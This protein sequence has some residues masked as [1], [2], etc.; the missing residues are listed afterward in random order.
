MFDVAAA[1][2]NSDGLLDLIAAQAAGFSAVIFQTSPGQFPSTP[3]LILGELS[4]RVTTADLNSDGQIDIVSA[5]GDHLS[6]Y[7]AK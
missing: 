6:V 7:F 5:N 4:A 1:D 2:L 3:S